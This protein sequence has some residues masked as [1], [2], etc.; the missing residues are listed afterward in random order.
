MDKS[1]P[2]ILPTRKRIMELTRR[3]TLGSLCALAAAASMTHAAADAAKRKKTMRPLG[4]QLYMLNKELEADFQGTLN[5]VAAIGYREVELAGFHNRT[6]AELRKAL[7]EAGL[8]C[9][10]V[11]IQ[12]TSLF[13]GMP[14]LADPAA[15]IEIMQVLGAKQLVVP[16]F[17][18]PERFLPRL[19]DPA[20]MRDMRRLGAAAWEIGLAMT[21]EDWKDFARSLNEKGRLFAKSGLRI[22]YHNHNVE[23]APL[24][25][26]GTPLEVLIRETDPALVSFELDVGWAASAGIDAAAFLN[27]YASRINQLHLKDTAKRSPPGSLE[28]FTSANL[29]AGIVDWP[30]LMHAIGSAKI[31]HVYVEQEEPFKEPPIDAARI[32]FNFLS[33]KPELM[34][35]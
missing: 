5:Q 10:S 27:R 6:G 3:Q 23:L 32:A 25:G 1:T 15:I 19:R 28:G 34:R 16:A 35:R 33:S 30:A 31:E 22:G 17:T 11:H 29:G 21:A 13:P 8:T 2:T 26:G 24:A 7:D 9:P 12:M 18:L 14:S 4:I 20:L